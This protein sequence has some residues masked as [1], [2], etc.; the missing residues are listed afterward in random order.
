MRPWLIGL[1]AA[2]ML[3]LPVMAQDDL[4]GV[5]G[6]DPGVAETELAPIPPVDE[7]ANP[8]PIIVVV[9]ATPELTPV[10]IVVTATAEPAPTLDPGAGPT[11]T[12]E[13]RPLSRA[14]ALRGEVGTFCKSSTRISVRVVSASEARRDI[15][16]LIIEARNLGTRSE[17]IYRM[18]DLR[19]EQ[20]RSFDMAGSV[21]YP[22][23]FDDLRLLR[24]DGVI[25]QVTNIQPG[26]TEQVYAAFLV[27]PDSASFRLVQRRPPCA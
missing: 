7:P 18:F 1:V 5:G 17:D 23:Y 22:Q 14:E 6:D 2:L 24:N 3:T 21:E 27:A 20:G 25:S 8:T 26:R 19:D 13:P 4:D 16:G 9:T 15:I 12:P 11:S 10:V